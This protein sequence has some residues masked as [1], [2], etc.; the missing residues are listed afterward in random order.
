MTAAHHV[1][2]ACPECGSTR[3]AR[4]GSVGDPANPRRTPPNSAPT[5]TAECNDCGHDW[6]EP[7]PARR[8]LHVADRPR[9]T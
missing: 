6:T 5:L 4:W 7:N 2:P 1:D 9:A 3:T 8:G